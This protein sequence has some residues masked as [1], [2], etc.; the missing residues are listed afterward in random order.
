MFD[1]PGTLMFEAL[2]PFPQ[3][4]ENNPRARTDDKRRVLDLLKI[5]F[6]VFPKNFV[7]SFSNSFFN[8]SVRTTRNSQT[9]Q[10]FVRI[11]AKC[12]MIK[13]SK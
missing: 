8:L 1:T 13:K 5:F 7:A 9:F 6:I 3:D 10:T 4:V 11:I 12:H 2:V